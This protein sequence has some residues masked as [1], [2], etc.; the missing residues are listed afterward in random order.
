MARS[1]TWE[2]ARQYPAEFRA[3]LTAEADA[4]ASTMPLIYFDH[5]Y[6]VTAQQGPEPYQAHLRQLATTGR[7]TFALSPM[8]WVEA[9]EDTNVAP[10]DSN[11]AFMDSLAP[12]WFFDRR[13]IQ[14]REVASVFFRHLR[15]DV[16]PRQLMGSVR[17]VIAA[18]VGQE[19]ERDSRAFVTHLRGIGP[20]I[21][22]E[23]S[24]Q[25]AYDTKQHITVLFR[26]VRLTL[27]IT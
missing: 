21:P 12:R 15:I 8:H 5:N 3:H 2:E 22:L 17:D 13:S 4:N 11:A 23:Q 10:G 19:A 16:N 18:L 1:A 27:A 6:V 25:K 24:L 9:A 14:R 7:A 20:N 26:K